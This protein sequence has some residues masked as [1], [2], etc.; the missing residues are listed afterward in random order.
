MD[1]IV[2]HSI[3]TVRFFIAWDKFATRQGYDLRFIDCRSVIKRISWGTLLHDAKVDSKKAATFFLTNT[4]IVS[5]LRRFDSN[6][7]K[8]LLSAC[9]KH[10]C[11]KNRILSMCWC[12]SPSFKLRCFVLSAALFTLKFNADDVLMGSNCHYFA[13]EPAWKYSFEMNSLREMESRG[14]IV[15]YEHCDR[16]VKQFCMKHYQMVTHPSANPS[17]CLITEVFTDSQ[18]SAFNKV[19]FPEQDVN[20]SWHTWVAQFKSIR[21][22]LLWVSYE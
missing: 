14:D 13:Y 1:G 6:E 17:D 19:W 18:T 9:C 22:L 8:F 2:R 11:D 3:Y 5:E 21:T 12:K 7:I 4:K 16:K 10:W 20:H 15:R